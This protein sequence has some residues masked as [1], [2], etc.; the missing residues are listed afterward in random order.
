MSALDDYYRNVRNLEYMP[1]SRYLLNPPTLDELEEEDAVVD[2]PPVN[3]IAPIQNIG[4]GGGGGITSLPPNQ[5]MGNFT[6]AVQN[7]Q[8]SLENPSLFAQKLYD[9]G[10]PQQR[11]VDQMMRDAT[12]FNM[13]RMPGDT[14]GMPIFSNMGPDERIAAIQ[15]YMADETSVGNY[16]AED[17]R[18]VRFQYGIPTLSSILSKVVPSS[19]YDKMTV[20]EQ[21][22]TQTKMGYK[23]PTIFGENTTGGNKDIFGRNVV[24]GFGNYVE[25]QKKD[26]AKLDNYFGSDLFDKR[27]G[28]DTVLEFDEETGQFMF[29]GPKA[30]AANRMNKLNLI[31]YNYDKKGINEFEQIK[32]ETGYNEVE[33]AQKNLIKRKEATRRDI[34]DDK[35]FTTTGG[36][37]TSRAGAENTYTGGYGGGADMGSAKPG[38]STSP[39]TSDQGYTDSGQYAGLKKGG[40]AKI[41]G[42]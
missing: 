9:F 25:K 31:R 40:L 16:P 34:L 36:I 29:K 22:Y 39:G 7:R 1:R 10:F 32:E 38:G 15:E 2:T 37:T 13:A 42:F 24:S 21:I 41:L 19:Y 6:S 20:P 17:P 11:S 8:Q 35:N 5:L 18:D 12:A 3:A 33:E 26:I 30:A 27:Y 14:R 4:G 28:K 23:G